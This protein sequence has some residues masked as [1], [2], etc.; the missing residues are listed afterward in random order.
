[1]RGFAHLGEPLRL[2]KGRL[3]L[4]EPVTV[5]RPMFMAYLGSVHGPVCDCLWLSLGPLYDLFESFIA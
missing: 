4:C 2:S 3:R 1:M 5:L